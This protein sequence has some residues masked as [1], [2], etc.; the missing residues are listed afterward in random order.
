MVEVLE[1]DR[2]D[3]GELLDLAFAELLPARPLDPAD[4]V[5]EAPASGLHGSQLPQPVGVTLNRQVQRRISRMQ[6]A[7]SGR[8]VRHPRDR[9]LPEHRPQHTP[10]IV[11][12]P[13]AGHLVITDN[14]LQALLTDRA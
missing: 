6:V 11:F 7:V 9:H 12:D 3:L 10:M 1:V 14:Q 8:A 13:T 4:G 2:G 5:L